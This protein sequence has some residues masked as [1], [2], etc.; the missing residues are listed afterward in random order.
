MPYG[1]TILAVTA[2][3]TDPILSALLDLRAAGH[4]AALIVVSRQP[5]QLMPLEL[6]VYFVRENWTELKSLDLQTSVMPT[7]TARGL[8][9]ARAA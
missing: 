8:D 9:W 4:P 5:E 2:L 1:A 3:V 7:A 6:P